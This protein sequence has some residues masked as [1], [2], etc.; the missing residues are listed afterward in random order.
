MA[1]RTW[2]RLQRHMQIAAD[3][4]GRAELFSRHESLKSRHGRRVAQFLHPVT[5]SSQQRTV[6]PVT[7]TDRNLAPFSRRFA[8]ASARAIIV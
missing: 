5:G 3:Q 7:R 1:A 6:G 8:S 2:T 4:A